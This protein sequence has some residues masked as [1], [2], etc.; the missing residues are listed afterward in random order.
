MKNNNNIILTSIMSSYTGSDQHNNYGKKNRPFYD[1]ESSGINKF[2]HSVVN[3]NLKAI[4]LYDTL[5]DKFLS[6]A[7]DN[8]TF[9]QNTD[10]Y[11]DFHNDNRFYLYR[12]YLKSS[13][14]TNIFL[15]DCNDLYFNKNPFELISDKYDLF[16]GSEYRD[17]G[18]FRQIF[19]KCTEGGLPYA[20]KDLDETQNGKLVRYNVGIIGG[21]KNNVMKYLNQVTK[22]MDTVDKA[23]FADTPC[24]ILT[25]QQHFNLNRIF[26]GMPLHNNFRMPGKKDK[27]NTRGNSYIVHK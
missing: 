18:W 5:S 19:H 21:T 25:L 20:W 10:H 22:L 1:Q 15:T 11:R 13:N 3:N 6:R 27:E 9:I 7:C 2:I 24:G 12:D 4:I 26:T 17:T 14:A 23:V 8:I 16:V